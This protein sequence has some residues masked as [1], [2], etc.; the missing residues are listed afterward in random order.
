M[1]LFPEMLMPL[2]QD[3][4]WGEEGTRASGVLVKGLFFI[5]HHFFLGWRGTA[6]TSSLSHLFFRSI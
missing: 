2:H 1:N 3:S 4:D 6:Y 5:H